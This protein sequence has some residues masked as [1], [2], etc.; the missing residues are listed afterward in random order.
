[1]TTPVTRDQ[2]IIESKTVVVH[3]PTGARVST[4]EYENPEQT[5]ST[6]NVNWGQ[7]GSVLPDGRDFDQGDITYMAVIILR[8]LA[9]SRA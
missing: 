6:V 1:M 2:F 8:E 5:A 9:A 3:R 4:Y 7:A